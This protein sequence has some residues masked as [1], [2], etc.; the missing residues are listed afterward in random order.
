VEIL[1]APGQKERTTNVPR[2]NAGLSTR[3]GG[4]PPSAEKVDDIQAKRDEAW[5]SYRNQLSE[6]WKSPVGR[7]DPNRAAVIEQQATSER[8]RHG[9]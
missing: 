2:R 9:A 7:L 1:I 8:W 3:D 6:A 5:N 4:V